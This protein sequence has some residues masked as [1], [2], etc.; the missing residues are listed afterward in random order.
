MLPSL[1][2]LVIGLSCWGPQITT[3]A[4]NHAASYAATFSEA[5]SSARIISA[6]DRLAKSFSDWVRIHAVVPSINIARSWSAFA[7]A[8][9]TLR[10]LAVPCCATDGGCHGER[11]SDANNRNVGFACS[12]LSPIRQI[13][14]VDH[15]SAKSTPGRAPSNPRRIRAWG[16]SR[17]AIRH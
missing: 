13:S 7:G 3:L 14:N 4:V 11:C 8:N 6:G 2:S 12:A 17:Y 5:V 1:I 10:G 16:R 15:Q 9:L